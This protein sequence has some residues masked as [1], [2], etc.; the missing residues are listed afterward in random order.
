MFE[1]RLKVLFN[2]KI[3]SDTYCLGLE[4]PKIAGTAKPGQ[5][6]MVRIRPGY[7]P[8]LRRPFSVAGVTGDTVHILYRVVGKGTAIMVDIHEGHVLDVLGPL[9]KGFVTDKQGG[10]C[11]L[12]GGGIG[13]A[14]L[15]FLASTLEGKDVEFLMGFRTSQDFFVY[16]PLAGK[17]FRVSVATD[18][19]S[20][21]YT[22]PVTGLLETS[23]ERTEAA[24][25]SVFACGP[26]AMLRRIAALCK[27]SKIPCQVSLETTMGCGLG[28]CLGCAVLC[29]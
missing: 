24:P 20:K 4:A 25:V 11:L 26:K 29:L 28:A 13:V 19:G 14:P 1:E 21:G 17:G 22:G 12:V 3:A 5:F 7:D 15:Y 9:G 18:D 10:K 16:E 6:V 27:S 23:L 8:L 2:K